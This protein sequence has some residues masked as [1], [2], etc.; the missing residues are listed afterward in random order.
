V[1]ALDNVLVDKEIRRNYEIGDKWPCCV[2]ALPSRW[3]RPDIVT[4][5]DQ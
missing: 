4:V 2:R 5:T 3:F 1:G